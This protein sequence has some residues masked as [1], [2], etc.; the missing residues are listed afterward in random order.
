MES[1]TARCPQCGAAIRPSARFCVTCGIKLPE[2]T[3]VSGVAASGWAAREEPVSQDADPVWAMPAPQTDALDETVAGDID[4]ATDTATVAA[5]ET[6][7]AHTPD[8]VGSAQAEPASWINWP[9]LSS[10]PDAS[11]E[12]LDEPEVHGEIVDIASELPGDAGAATNGEPAP[13]TVAQEPV[14]PPERAEDDDQTAVDLTDIEAVEIEP[15]AALSNDDASEPVSGNASPLDEA[16]FHELNPYDDFAAME[17]ESTAEPEEKIMPETII[18]QAIEIDV[19]DDESISED[20]GEVVSEKTGATLTPAAPDSLDRAN[21]LIDELRLLLPALAA[22]AVP[23]GEEPRD[24]AGI[25]ER[26]IA[27]RGDISFDRYRALREVVQEALTRPRD[28]EVVLR[29]SRRVEDM[30]A[31]IAEWD[32][33]QQAFDQLIAEME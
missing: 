4:D 13:D 25:R 7:Q 21:A 26:A 3:T 1:S 24:I 14:D 11:T 16:A 32:R 30:D 22:P 23:S 8:A 17:W 18:P 27:A 2:S 9:E 6:D 28:V 31:L 10:T 15:I 12:P 29:L 5:A 19:L 20:I 33:L